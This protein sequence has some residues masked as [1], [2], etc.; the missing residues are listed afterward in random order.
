MGENETDGAPT[1][2]IIKGYIRPWS[3]GQGEAPGHHQLMNGSDRYWVHPDGHALERACRGG[4]R[5]C[6]ATRQYKT[7]H[8][9]FT[10][11]RLCRSVRVPLV[12][13]HRLAHLCQQ[14]RHCLASTCG[15]IARQHEELRRRSP[16][17]VTTATNST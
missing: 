10:H 15:P 7:V 14:G 16:E 3:D 11:G 2:F 17:C 12:G 6:C 9:I 5:H 4:H 13:L 1:Y 8:N